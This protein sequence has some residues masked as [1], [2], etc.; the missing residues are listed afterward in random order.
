M[1]RLKE[2]N[3][4]IIDIIYFIYKKITGSGTEKQYKSWA[5]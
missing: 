4:G 2:E 1:N 3:L 5:E